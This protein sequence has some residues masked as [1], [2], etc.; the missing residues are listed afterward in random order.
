[1]GRSE[2]AD[3]E[4]NSLRTLRAHRDML[5]ARVLILQG[6]ARCCDCGGTEDLEG[7]G[8]SDAIRIRCASCRRRD[9][10]R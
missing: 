6:R 2:H 9:A 8:R 5:A 3:L 4:R 7:G 1:M 10:I